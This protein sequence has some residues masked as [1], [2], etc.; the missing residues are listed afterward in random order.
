MRDPI[1]RGTRSRFR[2]ATGE[3]GMITGSAPT[4][5]P[6]TSAAKWA[7]YTVFIA[8]GFVLA[9]WA[10][11]IP[12]VRDGLGVTPAGL[13]LIL[14]STA[15]GSLIAMPLSGMV[16]TRLGEA[17]TVTVMALILAAGLAT[18]A[19]GSRYGVPSVVVGLFL[20][21]FG[22]GTWDVAMNVQGAR[23]EQGLGRAIMARFHAA[24]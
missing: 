18:V 24:F 4:A 8:N 19:V 11:R 23:V 10:S 5:D 14:L 22:A 16:V 2:A 3:G 1:A 21:G 17:R 12:Q 6:V 7:V 20:L 15:I 9:S 13:G